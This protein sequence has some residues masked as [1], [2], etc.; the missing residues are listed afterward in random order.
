M[1][2]AQSLRGLRAGQAA[3]A[4]VGAA[5]SLWLLLASAAVGAVGSPD[6][7]SRAH[8]C[9]HGA[10]V[11]LIPGHECRKAIRPTRSA[12]L[13]SAPDNHDK[14]RSAWAEQAGMR[15]PAFLG[16]ACTDGFNVVATGVSLVGTIRL[17]N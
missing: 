16:P 13:S 17:L 6:D 3:H 2:T 9:P 1:I 4:C 14:A 15:F 8:P 11:D 12:F 5:V 10:A 7:V